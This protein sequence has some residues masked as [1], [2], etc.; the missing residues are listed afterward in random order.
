LSP[1]VPR[2]GVHKQAGGGS[3]IDQAAE[4]IGLLGYAVVDGGYASDW[5]AEL[6]ATFDRVLA[7]TQHAHGGCAELT[8]IDEHNTIRAPLA[9]DPRFLTLALNPTVLAICRI[10]TSSPAIL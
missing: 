10:N 4:M 5:L 9:A 6:S 3:P 2:Y 7:P 1:A 8:R